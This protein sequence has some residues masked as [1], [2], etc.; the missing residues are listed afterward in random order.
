MSNAKV[1]LR[2]LDS[3]LDSSV[4]LTLFGRAEEELWKTTNFWQAIDET[5]RALAPRGL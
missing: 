2:E 4:E 5:N 1:I 3:R